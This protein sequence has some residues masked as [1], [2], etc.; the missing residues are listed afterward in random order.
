MS[1]AP[2]ARRST[3]SGLEKHSCA[4][5]VERR[6]GGARDTSAIQVWPGTPYPLGATY[7][8]VGTNFSVFSEVAQRVELCLF[9]DAG[10]ETRVDLPEMTALCWHGYLPER[11][12]GAALRLPRPRPVGARAGPL[13]QPREAAARSLRQGDRRRVE[14]ERGAVPVSLRRSET[15]E[16]RSRQRAVHPEVGGHQPVLRL[17]QRPPAAHAVAPARSSTRRT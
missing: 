6:A 4:Q 11:A 2:P 8:G 7:D 5:R 12:A 16:E 1:R 3:P 13:V 15:L 14:L 9:N 10:T 17:G